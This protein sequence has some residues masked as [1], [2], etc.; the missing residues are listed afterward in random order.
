MKTTIRQCRG[1]AAIVV[2][3]RPSP[4]RGSP[5]HVITTSDGVV[6]LIAALE[7]ALLVIGCVTR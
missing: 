1:G 5:G 6:K 3:S 4:Y 7:R 2:E